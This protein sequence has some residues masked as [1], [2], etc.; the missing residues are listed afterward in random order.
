[1]YEF[2]LESQGSSMHLAV[3]TWFQEQGYD[4]WFAKTRTS[5]KNF[6]PGVT[7][8]NFIHELI[9]GILDEDVALQFRL[10]FDAVQLATPY[11]GLDFNK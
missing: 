4:H 11:I 1:M 6:L 10:A 3:S 7:R 9:V 5:P 8:H 2:M